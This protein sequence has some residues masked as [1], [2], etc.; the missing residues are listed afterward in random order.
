MIWKKFRAQCEQKEPVNAYWVEI[1]ASLERSLNY[2]HTGNA[3]VLTKAL[4]DPL[5]LS[6]SLVQD[7]LP[8]ISPI[9]VMS[10]SFQEPS[11]NIRDI[12]WPVR[13]GEP[14]MA[15]KRSCDVNY[16][17]EY[18]QVCS[19]TSDRREFARMLTCPLIVLPSRVYC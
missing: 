15:S 11:L 18:S 14:A 7:G 16:G 10:S 19:N 6:L 12:D 3:K 5:W 13:S 17:V 1:T 9:L 2:M 8:C 4:M